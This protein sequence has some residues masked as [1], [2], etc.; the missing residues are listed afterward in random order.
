MKIIII[1]AGNVGTNLH[2]AFALKHIQAELVS[3]RDIQQLALL[4]KDDG[5]GK[6]YLYTVADKALESVVAQVNAPK[7]LHI[8][9][10]GSM[11]ISI[12]GADKPH[13]GV[14]YCFQSFSKQQLIDDWT[15]IPIFV[16]GKTMDDLA[17]IYSVAQVLTSRVY[18][19]NQHDRERLHIA[20]VFAN[21]FTN[22]MYRVAADLLHDTQ[23][24]FQALIP[25]IESTAQKIQTLSPQQA[26]TGPASRMD[27]NVINHHKEVLNQSTHKTDISH[28]KIQ[29]LYNLLTQA[30]L[31]S[32]KPTKPL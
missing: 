12:F 20:G 3:S 5:Q 2:H 8:H 10:S 25:L 18:E 23:I 17:S 28:E 31:E 4:S 22:L 26:Q 13:A 9:T 15:N 16:E 19:A 30:I 7:A 21:N 1:G 27:V 29:Q 6:I 32:N 14:L 11:P 24:P